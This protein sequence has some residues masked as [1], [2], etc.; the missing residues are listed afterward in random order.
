MNPIEL[1]KEYQE[2]EMHNVFCYSATYTMDS[3][4]KG[5]EKEFH[6]VREK[7]EILETLI[8]NLERK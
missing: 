1:L 6:E 2:R 3:P 8:S 4:Q 5:D 7:A